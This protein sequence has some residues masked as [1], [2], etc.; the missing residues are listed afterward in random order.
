MTLSQNELNYYGLVAIYFRDPEDNTRWYGR[1]CSGIILR[2]NGITSKVLTARHCVSQGGGAADLPVA[3]SM[4]RLNASLAPGF[5]SPN[6]PS[7]SVTPTSI[8]VSPYSSGLSDT[9]QNWAL[10]NVPVDWRDR[11]SFRLGIWLGGPA[12]T[13]NQVDL[14]LGYGMN[15]TDFDCHIND[16]GRN[17][18]SPGV[19]RRGGVIPRTAFEANDDYRTWS[20]TL[21]GLAT[22]QRPRCGD[23]GGPDFVEQYFNDEIYDTTLMGVRSYQVGHDRY[24]KSA[25][26]SLWLQEALNGTYLQPLGGGTKNLYRA[27]NTTT[28][29]LTT[30]NATPWFYDWKTGSISD[31]SQADIGTTYCLDVSGSTVDAKVCNGSSAQKWELYPNTRIKNAASGRCL[32]APT[33]GSTATVATC[34]S[35]TT[36]AWHFHAQL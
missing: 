29:S 24:S 36:Q 8:T 12:R 28:V 1:P 18:Y 34:G 6:P 30:S 19:A 11:T 25:G 27:L 9:S 10:I 21:D 17:S 4:L 35:A 15:G 2:S 33:S 13:S 31:R 23:D 26:I 16:S 20:Y 7:G 14:V 3:P 5:P 32:T 22:T